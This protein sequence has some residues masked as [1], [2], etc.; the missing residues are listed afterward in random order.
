M[1]KLPLKSLNKIHKELDGVII[2]QVSWRLLCE[3]FGV[4]CTKTKKGNHKI[5]LIDTKA[6]CVIGKVTI[7]GDVDSLYAQLWKYPIDNKT[8]SYSIGIFS[9][10]NNINRVETINISRFSSKIKHK[11]KEYRSYMRE[12]LETIGAFE[13]VRE[14]HAHLFFLPTVKD[15]TKELKCI[16]KKLGGR[17]KEL[18]KDYQDVWLYKD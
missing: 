11:S 12:L 14:T 1:L 5:Y 16:K 6:L 3:P 15:Y 9:C 17:V 8:Y 4:L 10:K 7:T 18:M 13:K 2:N